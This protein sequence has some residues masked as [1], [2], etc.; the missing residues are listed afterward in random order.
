MPDF[1]HELILRAPLS[2]LLVPLSEVPDLVFSTGMLG[3]GLAIDPT[4]GELLAPCNGR[5]TQLASAGHALTLTA[6]NGAQILLHIGIDTV[7]LR[8]QGFAPCV[9]E[10]DAVRAGDVLIRFDVDSIAAAVPSLMTVLVIGN[11][12]DFIVTEVATPGAVKAGQGGLLHISPKAAEPDLASGPLHAGDDAITLRRS[13]VLA[14]PGGLHAR[15]AARA[16][17]AAKAFGA[18]VVLLYQGRQARLGSLVELLHLGAGESA[19][20]ELVASGADAAAA[21]SAVIAEL[22]REGTGEADALPE[23][24]EPGQAHRETVSRGPVVAAPGIAVGTLFWWNEVEEQLVETGQGVEHERHAL[25][26]AIEQAHTQLA[27]AIEKA[28]R[29]GAAGEAGI[30]AVHQALLQ[31]PALLAQADRLMAEGKSASFAWRVTMRAQAAS[32]SALDERRLAE[33]AGDMRDLEK[34]VLR[35]LGEATGQAVGGALV[36]PEGE[37]SAV[38]AAEEFTPSDLVGLDVSHVVALLMVGGGPTSHAAIIARQLGLPCLVAVGRGLRDVAQGTLIIV[39]ADHG[40]VDPAPSAVELAGARERV[41]QRN[42]R[43][44]TELKAS[45]DPAIMR[46]GVRIEVAANIG[47]LDD[48]H[49]AVAH[50][51][52]AIGLLRTEMLFISDSLPPSVADHTRTCQAIV[53]ALGGRS[54]IIRTLDIG[55]DKQVGYLDLPF[56][57]NPA[58]GLRG[59]RLAWWKPSLLED[60][61]RG[62]L[63]LRTKGPLRILLPMV[64]EVN[65]LIV[66]REH[67]QALAE[68]MGHS[69]P[70]E[71]GV[72]VEVPSAALLADQLAQY[73]D[74]LSI[75]TNDL[76]QYALAMDRGQPQL[77]G[78]LDGLH[79]G[80]L[81]LIEATVEGAARY[82]RWVGVCG[83]LAGD[84]LAVPVLVGLGVSELSVDAGLVP[85]VKARLRSLSLDE[86]RGQVQALLQLPSAQAVRAHSR[87]RWP[88]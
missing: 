59:I 5:V 39:D 7:K 56:E 13:F 1:N 52:D 67:I 84:L 71:L 77:A 6:A 10:N 44:E 60:Q 64:T 11:A 76:T 22:Q 86:C 74:F 46:D 21:A 33:R 80:V 48:A 24:A 17:A 9:A 20:L 12:E 88:L 68:S 28:E 66:L 30:F 38:L 3:P 2:G 78:R 65:E 37:V 41:R 51:A 79:P 82:G 8:G 55:A 31:D 29:H 18:E 61:L 85:S 36:L 69:Q 4:S 23:T 42:V 19:S 70:V 62:L 87:Q 75:G 54:V 47:N 49:Q 34:R 35:N 63:A 15:P 83:A 53:D 43:R 81:R 50:G 16:R 58:L 45:H 57:A 26:Q 14:C 25:G 73:A 32:L 72:M 40:R 27:A